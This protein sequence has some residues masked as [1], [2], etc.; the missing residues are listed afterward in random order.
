MKR[1]E[2]KNQSAIFGK[3]AQYYD[4]IYSDKNYQQECELVQR[5]IG[6]SPQTILDLGSGTGSHSLILAEMG[7]DITGLDASETALDIARAKSRGRPNMRFV[8]GNITS[9]SLKKEY[10]ACISMFCSICYVTNIRLFRKSLANIFDHL[11]PGGIL[12]FDFWNGN[13]VIHQ[14]P[15]TKVKTAIHDNQ[16]IIRIADSKLNLY[17]GTCA[18]NYH[19]IIAEDSRIVDEFSEIHLLSYY[20]PSE[21]RY[22]LDD[23]GFEKIEFADLS[24]ATPTN[25]ELLE[26]W[27][28][29]AIARKPME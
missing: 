3:F 11:R 9:F 18:I 12:I 22:M 19:C 25:D 2:A 7:F 29:Y 13:A 24:G 1:F 17:D 27:Y 16:R 6:G 8:K 28:I 23:A 21:V 14:R 15:T 4:A 5:I 10:D 20:F 26:K